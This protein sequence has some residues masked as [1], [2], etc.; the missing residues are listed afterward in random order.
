MIHHG[1][2]FFNW[3]NKVADIQRLFIIDVIRNR[4]WGQTR[5]ECFEPLGF[6]FGF[7]VVVLVGFPGYGPQR[8]FLVSL[9]VGFPVMWLMSADK[10]EH[11]GRTAVVPLV[12]IFIVKF[13]KQPQHYTCTYQTQR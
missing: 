12:V 4:Y 1:S 11:V 8:L 13:L 10:A 3:Q 2:N 6:L 9:L 5:S 7:S